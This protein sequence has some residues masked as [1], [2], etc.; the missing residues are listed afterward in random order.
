MGWASCKP[1][2]GA[3]WIAKVAGKPV[4]SFL[5]TRDKHLEVSGY[6]W[7]SRLRFPAPQE[8]KPLAVP[9]GQGLRLHDAQDLPRVEPAREPDQSEARRVGGTPGRGLTL[10]I[11]RELFAQEEIFGRECRTGVQ[12]EEQQAHRITH[13]CE[14]QACE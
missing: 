7:P 12:A 9:A 6:P 4:S 2:C 1:K 8:P 11:Q 14:K 13:Q 10:L 3:G 5:T